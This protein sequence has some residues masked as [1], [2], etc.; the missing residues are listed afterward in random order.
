[1][2]SWLNNPEVALK[3]LAVHIVM[4]R[5]LCDNQQDMI[6]C[7]MKTSGGP[8]EFFCASTPMTFVPS[9]VPGRRVLLCTPS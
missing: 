4:S 2:V 6:G 3:H 1:M 5:T 7:K 8:K 9:A